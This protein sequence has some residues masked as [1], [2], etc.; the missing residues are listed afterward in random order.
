MVQFAAR[1][2]RL[3]QFWDERF[4]G[5]FTPWDR[6]GV[7]Q[8]L[9]RFVAQAARPLASLIP[10]CGS[11]HELPWLSDAGW[12]A[13]AID[14]SP[15]AVALAK[16]ASGRWSERVVQADFF[17]YVP[18]W[19]LD[20]IYERAF[21]CAMPRDMW[22]HVAQRWAGL[23]P[24]GGLVAGFFFFGEAASGPPFGIARARLDQLLAPDFECVEESL[25]SDSVPAFDGKERWMVWRRR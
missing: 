23:L 14:F 7:P 8:A 17:S 25:V 2:P 5:G 3:P 18:P 22:P 6:A 21:L 10:G 9:R 20:L 11:G 13:V 16:A 4:A 15:A 24:A 12:K 1:D 19:P